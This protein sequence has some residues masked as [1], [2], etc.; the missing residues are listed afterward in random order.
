MIL[1]DHFIKTSDYTEARFISI[2]FVFRDSECD[3]PIY[4]TLLHLPEKC[5]DFGVIMRKMP[6]YST[7][8]DFLQV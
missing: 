1:C 5:F 3:I 7:K 2:I 6:F 8:N 4:H